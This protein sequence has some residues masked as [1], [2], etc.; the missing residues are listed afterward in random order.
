MKRIA[1][2]LR[3]HDEFTFCLLAILII[4]SI[5][6][7][8]YGIAQHRHTTARQQAIARAKRM[9]GKTFTIANVAWN[10][11]G[12]TQLILKNDSGE[13][14]GSVMMYMANPFDAKIN[15]LTLAF[16]DPY[17]RVPVPMKVRARYRETPWASKSDG[18]VKDGFT[19]SYIEFEIVK[20]N[21]S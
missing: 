18:K 19:G 15:P 13:N 8:I 1:N 12:D 2:F 7:G 4:G 21:A 17:G 14:I 16:T 3:R 20:G 10:F 5:A 6:S 11:V 9:D